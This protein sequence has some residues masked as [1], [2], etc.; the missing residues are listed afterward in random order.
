VFVWLDAF[1][2][3]SQIYR[4]LRGGHWFYIRLIEGGRGAWFWANRLRLNDY[5]ICEEHYER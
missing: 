1:F 3:N 5:I 2:S 4:I